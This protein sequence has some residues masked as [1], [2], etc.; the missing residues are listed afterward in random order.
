MV[1]TDAAHLG[2]GGSLGK[3]NLA[4]MKEYLAWSTDT[5]SHSLRDRFFPKESLLKSSTQYDECCSIK[6][7]DSHLPVAIDHQDHA[8]WKGYAIGL[9]K[10]RYPAF[11]KGFLHRVIA[12]KHL[13][14]VKGQEVD[15][16]NN[17]T[18]DCRRLNLRVC[19]KS[20]NN[21]N[22]GPQINNSSL[23]GY[24]GVAR[25][26]DGS[27]RAQIALHGKTKC[28]GFFANPREAAIAYDI[29]SRRFHE[30]FGR[31]N[32]PEASPEEIAKVMD[33]LMSNKT[34]RG[35][36]SRYYGVSWHIRSG[37]WRADVR[38][39]K[40]YYYLGY[41]ETEEGAARAVDVLL[42]DI[43]CREKLNFGKTEADVIKI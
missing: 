22:K 9:F 24:K 8:E 20:E 19:S 27:Y 28:I 2:D 26:A 36:T 23:H 21:R 18:L 4:A 35:D 14:C 29:Y 25:Y 40:R 13:G 5:W 43:G 16:R 42:L 31:V 37:K 33:Q 15:H 3:T 41:H 17:N 11:T 32:L 12:Q 30:G 6:M 7:E 1:L 34:N 39:Q 38:H 10:K